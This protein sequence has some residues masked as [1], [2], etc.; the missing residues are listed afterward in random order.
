M[1]Q[2]PN[3]ANMKVISIL[4]MIHLSI[5]FFPCIDELVQKPIKSEK[6]RKQHDDKFVIANDGFMVKLGNCN[7]D[8]VLAA[9]LENVKNRDKAVQQALVQDDVDDEERH[10]LSQ[11]R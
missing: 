4:P 9:L 6:T 8:Q 1:S 7:V 2:T 10:L 5:V 3:Q 11:M